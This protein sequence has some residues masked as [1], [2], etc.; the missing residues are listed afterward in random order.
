MPASCLA[1]GS[2]AEQDGGPESMRRLPRYL[3]V[4][5]LVC[6]QG[7]AAEDRG[8]SILDGIRDQLSAAMAV[9]RSVEFECHTDVADTAV[10]REMSRL[11]PKEGAGREVDIYFR[12]NGARYLYSR[13]ILE[14]GETWAD[15]VEKAFDGEYYQTC[16][17]SSGLLEKSK[18][19]S[20]GRHLRLGFFNPLNQFAFLLPQSRKEDPT[21][22]WDLVKNQAAWNAA[23]L[24]AEY[25][26]E[27]TIG[28]NKYAVVK[29]R[30][31]RHKISGTPCWYVV[32][33]DTGKGMFPF[34]W[35]SVDAA[36]RRIEDF[37]IS[38][39]K[40]V[41]VAGTSLHVP[42][43][44]V[45]HWYASAKYPEGSLQS[46]FTS[47]VSLWAFDTATGDFSYRIDPASV[48]K[49][50]DRDRDKIIPDSR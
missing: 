32:Y 12:S 48:G 31:G 30:G 19:D 17:R 37:E 20:L 26:G 25:R 35:R 27:E 23:F 22:G 34:R 29:F 10:F 45:M 47:D 7:F 40:V 24:D 43:K 3:A 6:A 2:Q 28:G 39:S 4:L 5:A 42:T 44:F 14:H 11:P 38:E 33:F 50:Y 36:G 13:T 1:S 16:F 8:H 15:T 18:V 9:P 41:E 46:T 21:V 49:V